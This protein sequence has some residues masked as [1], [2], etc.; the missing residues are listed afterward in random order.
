[1]G[2]PTMPRGSHGGL[3]A[4]GIRRWTAPLSGA[5]PR[6]AWLGAACPGLLLRLPRPVPA[7]CPPHLPMEPDAALGKIPSGVCWLSPPSRH[8]RWRRCVS[9]NGKSLHIY[10]EKSKREKGENSPSGMPWG[11]L[12][13]G[14]RQMGRQVTNSRHL[15]GGPSGSRQGRA[16]FGCGHRGAVAP[17]RGQ[18]CL[19]HQQKPRTT[20]SAKLPQLHNH[21]RASKLSL[22]TSLQVERRLQWLR[23]PPGRRAE[24]PGGTEALRAELAPEQRRGSTAERPRD[25]LRRL[26][27]SAEGLERAASSAGQASPVTGAL[28]RSGGPLGFTPAQPRFQPHHPTHPWT[29]KL[30]LRSACPWAPHTPSCCPPAASLAHCRGLAPFVSDHRGW[31][32]HTG[33]KDGLRGRPPGWA[34]SLEDKMLGEGSWEQVDS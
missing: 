22:G 26:E 21:N 2:G 18:A 33:G 27:G 20:G 5:W 9:I 10:W 1:M 12:G 4:V 29:Q 31:T 16:W 24:R 17:G 28:P 19:G 3:S 7:G 32:L 23:G 11:H 6:R 34:G 25:G 8:P 30:L 14:H 15:V 13:D